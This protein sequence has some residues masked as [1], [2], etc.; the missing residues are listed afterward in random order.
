MSDKN[1]KGDLSVL[2]ALEILYRGKKLKPANLKKPLAR[3]M[4]EWVY[5]KPEIT[6]EGVK[7]FHFSPPILETICWMLGDLKDK[8]GAPLLKLVL[9]NANLPARSEAALALGRLPKELALGPLVDVL[10]KD[11]DGWVR[12]SAFLGLR[13]LTGEDHFADWL[14]GNKADRADAVAKYRALAKGKK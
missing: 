8:E 9:A 14:Y 4:D 2:A 6:P 1:P 13:M 11:D 7:P 3:A 12:Y 10:E 5:Q